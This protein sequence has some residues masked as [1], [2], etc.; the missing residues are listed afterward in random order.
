MGGFLDSKP[1]LYG[2]MKYAG[3]GLA[4]NQK[5]M[6][7]FLAPL[8]PMGYYWDREK[9]MLVN[10]GKLTPALTHETPW[11]HAMHGTSKRC[12]LDHHVLFDI[13]GVI[14][15]R[16]LDCWKC[17]VTID[18]FED[19]MKVQALQREQAREHNMPCKCGIEVRDYT[20]KHYGAYYYSDSLD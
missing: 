10:P 2:T 12:G 7:S 14:P 15:H 8:V 16:C 5:D 3:K 20:P 6:I 9:D 18:T 4:A 19:L 11:D 17:C 1:S 13:Y